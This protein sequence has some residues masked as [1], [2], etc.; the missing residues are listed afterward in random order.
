MHKLLFTLAMTTTTALGTVGA[1][2]QSGS[3]ATAAQTNEHEVSFTSAEG[4]DIGTARLIGTGSGLL[5]RLDLR[6]LPADQWVALHIHENG[7][8]DASGN[9]ES[10]GGHWNVGNTSH[11]FLTETG[12]HSGDMPN[13]HVRADGRLMADVFNAQAFLTG[14][15]G[16]VMGRAIVVHGGADD[17]ESQPSG[18]AG[19]RIACAV[20]E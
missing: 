16:N 5:I 13:Q 11:G 17:Y 14:E 9:F 20:I 19:D 12:P 7:E 4:A 18:D 15:T 3:D 10:A 6:D 2:A 8:C 1:M